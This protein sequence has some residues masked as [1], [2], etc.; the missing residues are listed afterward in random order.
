MGDA[1]I[2]YVE[3]EVEEEAKAIKS[4]MIPDVKNYLDDKVSSDKFN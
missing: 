2:I 3:K 4:R 1:D